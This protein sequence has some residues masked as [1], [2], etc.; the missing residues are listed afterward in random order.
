MQ[1]FTDFMW[2][3]AYYYQR[4][5]NPFH[6]FYHG[7]TVSHSCFMFMQKSE[8]LNKLLSEDE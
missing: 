1:V 6:N 7:V 8:K 4:N 2:S 5:T 3:V